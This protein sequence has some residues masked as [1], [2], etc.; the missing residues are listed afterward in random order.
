MSYEASEHVNWTE[1]KIFFS[2]RGR[3]VE[4]DPDEE[5]K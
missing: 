3:P 2:Q 1:T 4:F 5:L